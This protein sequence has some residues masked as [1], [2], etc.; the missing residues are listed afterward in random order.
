MRSSIPDAIERSS[1]EAQKSKEAAER[2][3]GTIRKLNRR[4]TIMGLVAVSSLIIALFALYFTVENSIIA[5]NG[6]I[7]DLYQQLVQV[8]QEQVASY[9]ESGLDKKTSADGDDANV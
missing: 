9:E 1:Q 7:D 4:I 3:E 2:S 8:Q 6:R 5:Q